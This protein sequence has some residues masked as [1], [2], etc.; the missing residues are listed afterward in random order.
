MKVTNKSLSNEFLMKIKDTCLTLSELNKSNGIRVSLIKHVYPVLF[1]FGLIGN[2]LSLML[3]SKTY[4]QKSKENRNFLFC[5]SVICY[6]DLFVLI[7]GLFREYLEEII[8]YKI[9]SHSIYSCKFIF[10]SVY[11]F[12]SFSSYIY[13][14]IAA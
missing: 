12:S 3:I 13:A 9:R 2:C 4:R 11:F 5:L 1:I 7:F 10:L 6:S 8:G 14:F